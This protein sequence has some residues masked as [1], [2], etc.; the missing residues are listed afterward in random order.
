M[1]RLELRGLV[2]D[3]GDLRTIHGVDLAIEDGDVLRLRRPLGLR[4]VH[5][6]AH[7][8]GARGRSPAATS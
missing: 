2:K 1:A 5:A 4:Q 7:D 8:R 3:Y 6:P